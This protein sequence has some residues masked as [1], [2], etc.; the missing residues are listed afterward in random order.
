MDKT[1]TRFLRD[2]KKKLKNSEK[3]WK[4]QSENEE[5]MLGEEVAAFFQRRRA[6][7]AVDKSAPG[8]SQRLT[9]EGLVGH[10]K[11][12]VA[13]DVKDAF[14]RVLLKAESLFNG[15]VDVPAVA[16]FLCETFYEKNGDKKFYFLFFTNFLK[17]FF[18][19]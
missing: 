6:I 3:R 13:K 4:N 7:D 16:Q 19:K 1:F 5:E 2:K 12:P 8:E 18:C 9:W 17:I 11:G 10:H 15:A 14:E